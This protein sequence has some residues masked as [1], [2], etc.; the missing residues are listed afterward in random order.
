VI[1]WFVD[2]DHVNA[3]SARNNVLVSHPCTVEL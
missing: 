3:I 2:L 1:G